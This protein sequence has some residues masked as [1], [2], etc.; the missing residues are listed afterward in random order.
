MSALARNSGR[1]MRDVACRA[2]RIAHRAAGP[3]LFLGAAVLLS[4]C[5]S[6][7]LNSVTPPWANISSDR[8]VCQAGDDVSVTVR[9]TAP[10][11]R[12]LDVYLPIR[13]RLHVRRQGDFFEMSPAGPDVRGAWIEILP[14]ER[15]KVDRTF[16][17]PASRIFPF[18]RQPGWYE[19]WWE[20]ECAY[21]SMRSDTAEVRV[22]ASMPDG[23][24]GAE[25]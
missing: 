13:G 18:T 8:L 17:V 20:G 1:G 9:L 12:K 3:A 24:S 6:L 11:G 4:G 7:G 22:F 10:A 14:D 15:N 5:Q 21:C 23:F 16:A 2:L 19:I 25:R